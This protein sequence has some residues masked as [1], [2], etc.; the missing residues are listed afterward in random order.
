MTADPRIEFSTSL[1]VTEETTAVDTVGFTIAPG[2]LVTLLG[3]PVA[4]KTTTLRAIADLKRHAGQHPPK[5][6]TFGPVAQR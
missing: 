5:R 1:S 3:P 6:H 2:E 4:G